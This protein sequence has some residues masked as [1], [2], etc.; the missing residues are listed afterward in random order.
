[1]KRVKS[2]KNVRKKAIQRSPT[3]PHTSPKEVA[4]CFSKFNVH[5]NLLD[6]VLKVDSDSVGLR[7]LPQARRIEL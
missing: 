5:I 7:F 6:I 2:S 1:M 4:W 3:I